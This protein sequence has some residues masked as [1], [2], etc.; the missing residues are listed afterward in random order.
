MHELTRTYKVAIPL[1]GGRL[2]EHFGHCERFALLQVQGGKVLRKE[3]YVPPP[4]EPGVLPRWL[5]DMQ[6]DLVIAGGMG[7][8]ALRLFDQQKIEVITGAPKSTPEELV[9][10]YLSGTLVSGPN[11]CIH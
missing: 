10:S 8:K 2:T 9:Q 7:K 1:A 4:H 6:V 3:E 5:S 11:P